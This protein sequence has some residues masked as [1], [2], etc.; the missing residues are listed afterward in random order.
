MYGKEYFPYLLFK[1]GGAIVYFAK[2][3][4]WEFPNFSVENYFEKLGKLNDQIKV[5]GYIESKEHRFIIV[6]RNKRLYTVK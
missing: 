1:D 4:Q 2:I 5:K 3:I 6:C